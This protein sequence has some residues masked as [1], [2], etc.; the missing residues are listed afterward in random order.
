MR[1]PVKL[2]RR[3]DLHIFALV[4]CFSVVLSLITTSVWIW[5]AYRDQVTVIATTIDRVQSGFVVPLSHSLWE[6]D[7]DALAAEVA[8]I[9]SQPGIAFVQVTSQTGKIFTAGTQSTHSLISRSIPISF[10]YLDRQVPVGTLVIVGDSRKALAEVVR[11]IG[12]IY[13]FQLV[14]VGGVATFFFLLFS[15]M[16]TR[17]LLDVS[18]YLVKIGED[19]E[20]P[21]LVLQ[22][23]R[24]NDELD[25]VVDTVNA[26]REDLLAAQQAK[27]ESMEMFS[28]TFYAAP[29][30]M[31]ISMLEDGTYLEV[32]NTFVAVSG[33]TREEAVGKRSVDLGWIQEVDRTALKQEMLE[34]GRVGLKKLSLRAK[35]GTAVHCLFSGEVISVGNKT[36]LL[37]IAL[38]ITDQLRTESALLES[39]ERY[40]TIF[41][42]SQAVMLVIDPL[43]G[44]IVDA[45]PAAAA[46][47]G[48]PLEQLLTVSLSMINT[49]NAQEIETDMHSAVAEERNAFHFRH[50]LAS[51]ELRDVQVFSSP[52]SYKG[53]EY[54]YL[55]IQDITER[56]Q[57]ENHVMQLNN[58]LE[59][60]VAERTAQLVAAN[61]ELESFS[62]S[63][64][65]DLRAPVR[66]ISAFA[67]M[68]AE[69]SA[70]SLS[71]E[72]QHFLQRIVHS[73]ALMGKMIE[74]LLQISRLN[75][76]PLNM[77]LVNLSSLAS[78]IAENCNAESASRRVEWTIASDILANGDAVLL[79]IVLQNLLGNAWKYSAK[80]DSARIEFCVKELAGENVYF[81]NDNGAGFDKA[82]ADRMFTAFQRLHSSEEFAGIGIG[83]AT[84]QRI[85]ALHGGR[86]WADGE[87]DVGSTFYFTLG[88][89]RG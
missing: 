68:L 84:V 12:P 61:H 88:V 5:V 87:P 38:D 4:L 71:A 30:L 75:Q 43:D 47:Y 10:T 7:E 66:H 41:E 34:R 31:T 16:I 25:L 42:E 57:A 72:S 2:H 32:N 81:I 22:R 18:R 58:A 50:R 1:L 80:R 63:V 70:P 49:H 15:R 55:I 3:L 40:R 89:D 53:G 9:A 56:V 24:R 14:M 39:E 76:T 59:Q 46:Y 8:G 65:H 35:D 69:A 37:S 86:V 45:N 52:V 33:F 13:L 36:C 29:L 19:M 79:R 51:G 26:M 83:L 11:S 21:C 6:F 27:L 20:Q 78:E 67:T 82:H 73:S 77:E 54:L 60:R 62:Y 23:H 64:S 85:I 28:R 44:R 17:H 74:G 48:Y